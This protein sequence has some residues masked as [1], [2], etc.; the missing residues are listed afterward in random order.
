MIRWRYKLKDIFNIDEFGFKLQ[1]HTW[2]ESGKCTGGKQ[3]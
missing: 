2:T 1:Q 3:S